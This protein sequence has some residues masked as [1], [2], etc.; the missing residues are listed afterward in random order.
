[1]QKIDEETN[2]AD[3]LTKNVKADVQD[4]H[5]AAMRF[6][7]KDTVQQGSQR[8]SEKQISAV[9]SGGGAL[10]TRSSRGSGRRS[11]S[12]DGDVSSST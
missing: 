2:V 3:N 7:T 5:T 1:M 12:D 11:S 6:N 4:E 9:S 10:H 8:S